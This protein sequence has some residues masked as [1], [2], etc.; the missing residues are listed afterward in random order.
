MRITSVMLAHVFFKC[1]LC[2]SIDFISMGLL[3]SDDAFHDLGVTLQDIETQLENI[4]HFELIAEAFFLL[5]RID[6][7]KSLAT[8]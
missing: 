7:A 5:I 8:G 4:V 6:V 2:F 3:S 1:S